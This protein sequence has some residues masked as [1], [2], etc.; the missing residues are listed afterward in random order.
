MDIVIEKLLDDYIDVNLIDGE[1][2]SLIPSH[3]RHDKIK[4]DLKADAQLPELSIL[5]ECAIKILSTEDSK[6][7]LDLRDY[8]KMVKQFSEAGDYIEKIDLTKPI[9]ED[10]ASL[11]H[12]DDSTMQSI[13]KIAQ[14]KYNENKIEESFSIFALL[15]TLKP[16]TFDYWYRMGIIAHQM[17]QYAFALKA[18]TNATYFYP[19]LLGSRIFSADCHLKLGQIENAKTELNEAKILMEK[20]QPESYWLDLYSQFENN[21]KAA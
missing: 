18:F 15:S 16:E 11:L 13:F 10:Y 4:E 5:L 7:Y 1:W 8:E 12:F 9:E 20:E 6:H 17:Q 2:N 19:D 3:L 14:E 21:L